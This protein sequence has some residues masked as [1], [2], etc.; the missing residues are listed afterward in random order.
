[1]ANFSKK[2]NTIKKIGLLEDAIMLF[3]SGGQESCRVGTAGEKP[4]SRRQ[5]PFVGQL[6]KAGP[7]SERLLYLYWLGMSAF[8]R[9][10]CN[11]FPERERI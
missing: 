2:R 8:S 11:L 4:T 6:T 3:P 1:V 10:R 5:C 9:L 7:P